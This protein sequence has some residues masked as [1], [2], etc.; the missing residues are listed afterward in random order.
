MPL[1]QNSSHQAIYGFYVGKDPNDSIAAFQFAILTLQIVGRTKWWTHL[2]RQHHNC[3]SVLKSLVQYFHSLRCNI[4][5]ITVDL[6]TQFPRLFYRFRREHLTQF[7]LQ[8]CLKLF[9]GFLQ[10]VFLKMVLAP[11]PGCFWIYLLQCRNKTAVRIGC[12]YA[13]VF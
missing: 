12:Y 5:V 1:Y 11:L 3:H 4:P 9:R 2:L 10:Y 6:I 8:S 7:R 13:Y